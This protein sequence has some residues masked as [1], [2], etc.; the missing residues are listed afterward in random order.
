MKKKRKG[1][2]RCLAAKGK[3]MS[4]DRNVIPIPDMCGKHQYLLVRQCSYGPHDPWRALLV[5]TQ[6]ALFQGATS[7]LGVWRE[8]DGRVENL[9]KIGCLA[10]RKPDLFGELVDVVQKS[11]S[12]T[13]HIQAIKRRGELWVSS[14]KGPAG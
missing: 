10:C 4:E 11:D 13:D 2:G 8:A 1:K 5:S 14:A 6:I 3:S 12:M 9:M 7:D